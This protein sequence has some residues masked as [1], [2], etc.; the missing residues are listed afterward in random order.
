MKSLRFAVI[1]SLGH[2][3]VKLEGHQIIDSVRLVTSFCGD[4]MT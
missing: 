4:L 3:V 2:H 1:E